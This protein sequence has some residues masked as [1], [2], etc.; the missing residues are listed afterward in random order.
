MTELDKQGMEAGLTFRLGHQWPALGKQSAFSVHYVRMYQTSDSK[1][2]ESKYSL[3]YLRDKLTLQLHHPVYKNLSA[4]WYF[5]FQKRMG[6][7]RKY[8][9]MTDVGL[10]PYPGFSTL[11]LKLNYALRAF[12]FYINLNNMY[13]TRYYDIGNVPQAGFW[14]MGGLPV[15]YSPRRFAS[16]QILSISASVISFRERPCRMVCCSK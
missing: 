9:G 10:H 13:D 7:Y 11:D 16:S 2:L 3:N 4:G 12:D 1:G 15:S 14:L 5:R 6:N 8:E